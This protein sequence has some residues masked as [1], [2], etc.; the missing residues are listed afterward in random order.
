MVVYVGKGRL[1]SREEIDS[2]CPDKPASLCGET[3][4][5]PSDNIPENRCH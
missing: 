1:V 2:V 5:L 3:V 4:I